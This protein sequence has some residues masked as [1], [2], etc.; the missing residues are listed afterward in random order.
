[1]GKIQDCKKPEVGEAYSVDNL[2]EPPEG[3]LF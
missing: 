3:L 1:M 2:P